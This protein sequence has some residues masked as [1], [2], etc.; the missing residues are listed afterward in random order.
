MLTMAMPGIMLRLQVLCPDQ[1]EQPASPKRDRG[2]FLLQTEAPQAHR[3]ETLA[4]APT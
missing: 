3:G 1:A 4:A 2:A